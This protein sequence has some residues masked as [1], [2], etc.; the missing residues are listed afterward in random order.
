MQDRDFIGEDTKID[1]F[2]NKIQ[3]EWG[4]EESQLR[5]AIYVSFVRETDADLFRKKI[6]K[7]RKSVVSQR[8]IMSQKSKYSVNSIYGAGIGEER[9]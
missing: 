7:A 4:K 3:K 1:N 8:S 9:N 2:T 5:T 6:K